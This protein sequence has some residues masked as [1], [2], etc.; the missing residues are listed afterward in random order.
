MTD[1]TGVLFCLHQIKPYLLTKCFN[2]LVMLSLD[3]L[4]FLFVHVHFLRPL[5]T[6]W[7]AG[8]LAAFFF[9]YSLLALEFGGSPNPSCHCH[10]HIFP[11]LFFLCPSLTT[12]HQRPA[13]CCDNSS[14]HDIK[15]KDRLSSPPPLPAQPP[16]GPTRSPPS[17]L[18]LKLALRGATKRKC[19]A[20]SFFL[21][22]LHLCV[23]LPL[24]YSVLLSGFLRCLPSSAPGPFIPQR[25]DLKQF[26]Y[27]ST[28]KWQFFFPFLMVA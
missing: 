25:P 24:S 2:C 9:F 17:H 14:Y 10:P 11:S 18:G 7:K 6:F 19:E 1:K 8:A 5:H 12:A 4:L 13:S 27:L 16:T 3:L 22:G 28:P 15:Q 23:S 21:P 26:F 20:N